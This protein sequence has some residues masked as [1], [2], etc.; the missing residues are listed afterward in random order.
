METQ[1]IYYNSVVGI[2]QAPLYCYLYISISRSSPVP[3]RVQEGRW[4]PGSGMGQRDQ[5]HPLEVHGCGM[6]AAS[7]GEA[8]KLCLCFMSSLSVLGLQIGVVK[9]RYLSFRVLPDK[10]IH[11]CGHTMVPLA[12]V[13]LVSR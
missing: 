11:V 12:L 8:G 2:E 9:V 6:K 13:I 1:M 3:R 7:R 4:D 5:H 10:H